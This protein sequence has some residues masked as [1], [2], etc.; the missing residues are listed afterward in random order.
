MKIPTVKGIIARRILANFRAD[1][2]V[3]AAQLPAPFRP[4]LRGQHA[5]VGICLI[6]L[7][8]IRPTFSPL[9]CGIASENA[10][11]RVA[12][13]WDDNGQTREGVF[14]ARRDT[15]SRLNSWSGGRVFP[16]E[17]H[18]AR[19]EVRQSATEFEVA[20]RSCD[21]AVAV[22]VAGTIAATLPPTSVF[23]SLDE[24]SGFF[25][26]GCLGYS[27]RRDSDELDGLQLETLD[28]NVQALAVSQ[29][30]SSVFDD[31]E[32]FPVGSIAFDHA[33]LMRNIEHQWHAAEN[34]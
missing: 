24:A 30:S 21:G 18:L 34:L 10:A 6:R 9:R 29:I 2:G 1:A 27:A 22:S 11:H 5:I 31:H 28:W 15:D 33:L 20:M 13:E 16:G 23:E 14:I 32:K 19:F 17:H 26:R 7:E 8:N 12:V 3:V 4:K 25:E